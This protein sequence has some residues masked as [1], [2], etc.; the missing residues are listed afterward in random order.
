MKVL[1]ILTGLALVLSAW[2]DYGKTRK[3][4][5]IAAKRFAKLLG[6]FAL[7]LIL[8]SLA[9]TALPPRAITSYLEGPGMLVGTL[10][11]SLV[12]S[13]TF[14]PGFISY[15]LAG[16]LHSRGVPYTVL[17]AFVTTLMMVGVVTFPLEQ[18]FLGTKVAV[19]R[20]VLYFCLALV[21]SLAIGII[22]GEL[23]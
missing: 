1:Y 19:V 17:A 11:A 23:P 20:N 18:R 14:I 3:A 9:L 21:T 10:L 6:E 13:V 7:L 5:E 16:I 22:F 15:P 2:A 12:G 4:L 8:V